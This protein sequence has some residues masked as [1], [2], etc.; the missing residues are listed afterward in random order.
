MFL[1]SAG[2]LFTVFQTIH[3]HRDSSRESQLCAARSRNSRVK[4]FRMRDE[5]E[6]PSLSSG[7][8]HLLLLLFGEMN[9]HCAGD[10]EGKVRLVGSNCLREVSFVEWSDTVVFNFSESTDSFSSSQ[11]FWTFG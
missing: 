3:S 11:Y 2:R 7:H 4:C 10:W 5:G 6:S 9:G 1:K 8:F